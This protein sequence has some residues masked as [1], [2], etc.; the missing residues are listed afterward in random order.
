M[1]QGC[2]RSGPFSSALNLARLGF[3]VRAFH[4][5][6]AQTHV[7]SSRVDQER[8]AMKATALL[9][10]VAAVLA[11]AVPAATRADDL[12]GCGADECIGSTPVVPS[13]DPQWSENF[14]PPPVP[15]TRAATTCIPTDVIFYAQQTDWLRV[16]QKMRANMSL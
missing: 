9:T 12:Q 4:G 6:R 10:L 1:P 14:V 5:W 8:G 7:V 16:A 2:R 15:R 11:L 3:V 13:L